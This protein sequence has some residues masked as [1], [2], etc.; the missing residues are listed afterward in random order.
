MKHIKT[1]ALTLGTA[2]CL[3]AACNNANTSAPASA[4]QDTTAITDTVIPEA[5]KP[6]AEAPAY[7]SEDR[8]TFALKGNVKSVTPYATGE[9]HIFE[10]LRFD[11]SG[12][13]KK[14]G[15]TTLSL[16]DEGFMKTLK[17]STGGQEINITCAE[18][19]ENGNPLSL[20]VKTED[21]FGET[22]Y[23][24]TY[25]YTDFDAEGN[26][27][28]CTVKFSRTFI[29]WDTDAEDKTKGSATLKRKISYY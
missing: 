6:A 11:E 12:K 7:T 15:G 17:T 20:T 1:L 9:L 13:W 28:K 5:E 21:Q 26:W 10:N 23:K 4:E 29:N 2:G 16:N 22:I 27:T 18:H 3:F 14:P 19:D 8:K 24:E 25:T